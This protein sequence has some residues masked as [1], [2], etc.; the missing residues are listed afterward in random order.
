MIN[1]LKQNTNLTNLIFLE[2]HC[3]VQL[4]KGYKRD[5]LFEEKI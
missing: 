3:L 4:G 2:I 1:T 5:S